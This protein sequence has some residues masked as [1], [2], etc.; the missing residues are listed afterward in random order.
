MELQHKNLIQNVSES[1][2]KGEGET[3][4][5]LRASIREKIIQEVN[6]GKTSSLDNPTL[7][8]YLEKL[9]HDPQKILDKDIFQL[10]A[11]G[12]SE[13]AIYEIT[14]TAAW[15]AGNSRLH[16]AMDLINNSQS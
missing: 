6:T 7:N 10:K 15:A 16:K 8:N 1:V 14:V 5:T 4:T 2:Y 11:E 9:A 12:F 13:D 3:Q